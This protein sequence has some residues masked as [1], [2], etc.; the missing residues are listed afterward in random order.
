M[1]ILFRSKNRNPREELAKEL[2]WRNASSVADPDPLVFGHPK[3]ESGSI[4]QR[5]GFG[6]GSGS[7]YHQ[8]KSKKNLDSWLFIFEND[9]HV[10]SKSNK[11][12]N[13][14]KN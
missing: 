12:K 6:S 14:S 11:Q 3:S 10:P 2:L 9:V 1:R 8:A 13:F 5:Y 7:F 4:S